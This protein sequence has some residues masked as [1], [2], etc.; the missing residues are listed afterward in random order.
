MRYRITTRTSI[1]TDIRMG[2]T[3]IKVKGVIMVVVVGTEVTSEE[4]VGTSRCLKIPRVPSSEILYF[5]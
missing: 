4:V 1:E 2:R 5:P 3:R